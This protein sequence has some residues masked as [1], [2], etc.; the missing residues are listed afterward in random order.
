[1]PE[2]II[3]VFGN[4]VSDW[5]AK[6]GNFVLRELTKDSIEWQQWK[7][8]YNLTDSDNDFLVRYAEALVSILDTFEKC[9]IYGPFFKDEHTIW[10]FQED[11]YRKFSPEEF[12]QKLDEQLY[13]FTLS[14]D[15]RE[16]AR[17]REVLKE[18]VHDSRSAKQAEHFHLDLNTNEIVKNIQ[19]KVNELG[20]NATD[21]NT[22][23]LSPQEILSKFHKASWALDAWKSNFGK[24]ADTHLQ[25][26]ETTQLIHW[27]WA[28]LK[29]KE[30][31]VALLV[32]GAGAGK[33]V[34]LRDVLRVLEKDGIPVLG[35]KADRYCV[36]SIGELEKNL[37]I[38]EGIVR[39]VRD[40]TKTS[41]RIVVLIDQIDALSQTLSARREYFETFHRLVLQLLEIAEVR[42]VV[43]IRTY[44]LDND[45]DFSF[46]REQKYFQVGKLD[47]ADVKSILQKV[48]AK[49]PPTDLLE[50]LRI[51]LHLDVFCRIY[52][53]DL[54]FERITTLRNLY[55]ELWVQKIIKIQPSAQPKAVSEKCKQLVYQLAQTMYE[56][57]MLAIN[58]R[59]FRESFPNELEYFKSED[60]IQ[61][62]TEGIAF[63][64][65]TFYDYAFARQFIESG[66]S[67]EGYLEENG[68]SLHIRACL[69]M[70]IEFL[71]EDNPS[72][73]LRIY[74]TILPSPDYFFH[75]KSLLL[76]LLGF[77]PKP[78]MEE[79]EIARHIIFPDF[80]LFK[81]FVAA[82][83][84][85]EW[86]L[87][88]LEEKQLERFL[89]P[90]NS[91][92]TLSSGSNYS[93]LVNG[94]FSK[95]LPDSRAE[96]LEFLWHLPNVADKAWL[97][98]NALH[99]LEDWDNPLAFKLFDAYREN[100][101]E[102][103]FD[104]YLKKA[105]TSNFDW[106]FSHLK[107]KI[108][109]RLDT[110][111]FTFRG[112]Q[113]DY[114][115]VELIKYFSEHFPEATFD[116][117]FDISNRYLD[118]D[119]KSDENETSPIV[120]DYP[121]FSY[122]F[123]RENTDFFSQ[124]LTCV[125][126]LSKNESPRFGL[127]IEKHLHS[128]SG[129]KLLL[130]VEGFRAN[131]EQYKTEILHFFEIFSEKNG[132]ERNET[133]CWYVRQLLEEAYQFFTEQQKKTAIG[134]VKE[135]KSKNDLAVWVD[136]D[137]KKQ[138]YSQLGSTCFLWLQCFPR[139]DV[140][141]FPG[142]KK[143]F[144]E[145]ERRFD[146]PDDRQPNTIRTWGVEAPIPKMA[147]ERMSFSDWRRSFS[148]YDET[149]QP[150]FASHRGGLEQNAR[151]FEEEIKKRPAFFYPLLDELT[152]DSS[153][154]K[155]YLV[156]GLRGLKEA[157]F[158]P[159]KI[160]TLLKKVDMTGWTD[161]HVRE[162]VSLC[163]YF[164]SEKVDDEFYLRFLVKM[165]SGHPDPIDETLKVRNMQDE[166]ESIY[167]TGYNSVRGSA[168]AMLPR[169]Y[170]FNQYGNLIFETLESV[171]ENDFLAVRSQMMPRLAVL[172]NLD[173]ER[174]LRL[175]L[176]LIRDNEGLVME[177]ST[178]LAR[179]LARFNFE[180]MKPYFENAFSHPKLHR[181]MGI[182][183]SEVWIWDLGD[184]LLLLNQFIERSDETKVGVIEVAA[185]NITDKDRLPNARSL[186]LLGR[187][188]DETSE[189]V[190]HAYDIA[191][192]HLKPSDFPHLLP[193]LTRF[194]KTTVARKNPRPFYEYLITCAKKHPRECLDLVSD[195]AQYEKPDIRFA[196]HYGEEPFKVVI[197]AYNSLLER[198]NDNAVFL[199]EALLLFDKMLL[200]DRF[201]S[202]AVKT[203]EEVER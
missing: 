79:K 88:L 45:H 75:I 103:F 108:E 55:D 166:T 120:W 67:L 112:L 101:H 163:D 62:T 198:K 78:T 202:Y 144:Q 89:I 137:G 24:N 14:K 150:E 190:I 29:P 128:N 186:E 93:G 193:L 19:Q 185:H 38:E 64:H 58:A 160:L 200:D 66:K 52:H 141:Q 48:S 142:F 42:I 127:Y 25:R 81:E 178:R 47:V 40:L 34:I 118:R 22:P 44:D 16:I 201:R 99:K 92:N 18:K 37:Y 130:L 13:R 173:K 23:N 176:R 136:R 175:F 117:L 126:I 140:L 27:I 164:I 10:L 145:M 158:P 170:F 41:E 121:W 197:N 183:L 90:E 131:P 36:E 138:R 133:L 168:I 15:S 153:F 169:C 35:I 84:S 49:L 184:A 8:K 199:R 102:V 5:L 4:L 134:L 106:A 60:I 56:H 59:K 110:A 57:Q 39:C 135:I 171:A 70:I 111:E 146:K 97:V 91:E 177:H 83:N 76:S 28:P 152:T 11:W 68:Q 43:S 181:D 151:A 9:E 3:G 1:M 196:G 33:S 100:I 98:Q 162:L 50:L 132:Y 21:E 161:W 53:P 157:K 61:E 147:Y 154:S 32:G 156:S 17:F 194:A 187:F 182:I 69:K 95:H 165:A 71:R 167:L 192:S 195:F 113:F 31:G 191:F 2:F 155:Q 20:S 114:Q 82:V 104:D 125:R 143:K 94:L 122:D 74:K 63:F 149:Y 73:Y 188:L 105:A 86:L 203:L 174:T 115:E 26:K 124:L 87:F 54:L 189:T 65:Q 116:L 7:A 129:T 172:M 30:K 109:Q 179:Y 77:A 12:T 96:I 80:T 159:D 46:Y 6:G 72:E 180:E 119:N 107:A 148:K 51:P 123:G 139:E 85:R